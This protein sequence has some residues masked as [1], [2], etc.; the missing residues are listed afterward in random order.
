MVL[1]DSDDETIKTI[2]NHNELTGPLRLPQLS[3]DSSGLVLTR[4]DSFLPNVDI[5]KGPDTYY[6]YMDLP[7]MKKED[8]SVSR[9]NVTTIVKGKRRKYEDESQF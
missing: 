1:Q 3:I 6:I 7:G 9:M 2:K 4:P 5:I 8:V